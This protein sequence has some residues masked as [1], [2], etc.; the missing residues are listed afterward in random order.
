MHSD[1]YYTANEMIK[2]QIQYKTDEN[3]EINTR[4][5]WEGEKR[6]AKEEFA[7]ERVRTSFE[8]L[9]NL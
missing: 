2:Q 7:K 6:T 9:I 8:S 4:K 3:K 5:G 1:E